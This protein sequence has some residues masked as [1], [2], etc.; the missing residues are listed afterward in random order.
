[1]SLPP[2]TFE[3]DIKRAGFLTIT[4]DDCRAGRAR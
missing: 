3:R 1:M 4:T 2:C